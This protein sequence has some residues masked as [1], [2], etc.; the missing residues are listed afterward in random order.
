VRNV[1]RVKH[2]TL[3]TE[4]A[5]IPWIKRFILFH[6]KC[7]PADMGEREIGEFLTHLA[8]NRN[9]TANTQNQALLKAVSNQ[10][11]AYSASPRSGYTLEDGPQYLD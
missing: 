3:N 7:H 4:R 1:I 6:K 10:L 5:Y 11:S 9:V 2:Y 8:V